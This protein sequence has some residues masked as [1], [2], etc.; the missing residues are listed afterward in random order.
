M[1][2]LPEGTG[3]TKITL[4][5]HPWVTEQAAERLVDAIESM[6]DV[7]AATVVPVVPPWERED[8]DE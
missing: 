8:E 4:V 1:D 5:C 2:E 6:S 3:G 7:L